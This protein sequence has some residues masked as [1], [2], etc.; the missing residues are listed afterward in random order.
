[1]V[2]LTGAESIRKRPPIGFS[3][4][5][6]QC[7][8]IGLVNNMSDAALEA[9]ERQFRALLTAAAGNVKVRLT[10]YALPEVPRS[11]AG[12]NHLSSYADINSLW[13]RHLDGL[14]VTGAEPRAPRLMDEPYWGSLTRLL[15]WADR[16]TSSSIW[17][18]LAAHAAVLH[19]D[20]IDRLP[21]SDKRFGVFVS[22]L[23]SDHPLMACAPRQLQMPHSR[24]NDIPED[25]MSTGGYHVLTRSEEAGIDI[26]VKQRKS[27]FVLF[28]GHPEYGAETL[29]LEYRRD[30]R[31]FLRGERETY[32]F[33]PHDYFA[34]DA[35]DALNALQERARSD[36]R[37]ELLKEFPASAY[38]VTNTWRHAATSIYRGW[39]QYLCAQKEQRL[40]AG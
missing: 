3:E 26:F 32:P 15:D 33:M 20:G 21:Y 9:T 25:A 5:D 13:D 8:D 19:F 37:E 10:F 12:R 7:L 28:Q 17:S 2:T 1:M 39:L 35:V 22:T 36:R 14:I 4:S 16:E 30:I 38:H 24:W 18:C 11:E 31:R 6:P 34:P 23:V 40:S 29:L 27:L